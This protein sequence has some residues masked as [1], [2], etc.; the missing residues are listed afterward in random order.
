METDKELE[1]FTEIVNDYLIQ[2]RELE[3]MLVHFVHKSNKTTALEV[4]NC[5]RELTRLSKNFK[6]FSIKFFSGE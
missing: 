3:Y 5:Q 2:V 4:R 6:D 1:K